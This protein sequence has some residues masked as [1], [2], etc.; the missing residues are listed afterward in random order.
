MAKLNI[1]L[2]PP[3][4]LSIGEKRNW[5][6]ERN[7]II[8][9][10]VV[11]TT[12]SK[13]GIPNA[14]LKTNV[15]SVDSLRKVAF[16]CVPEH[17]TYRNILQTKGFVVNVP[18]E[19]IIKETL[20]TAIPFPPNVKELEKAG[21]TTIPSE[22]VKPPRIKEC[23]VHYECVCEWIKDNIILGKIVS[24]SA[25]KGILKGKETQKLMLILGP[26]NQYALVGEMKQFPKDVLE[27]SKSR[28]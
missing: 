6:R 4:D 1:P 23:K 25:D 3:K 24:A 20:V 21:L 11:V 5:R 18:D 9:P 28:L 27:G 7:F 22:K 17:D 14:A 16:A 19:S 2:E 13:E 15:M 10:I 12:V 8:R 26:P